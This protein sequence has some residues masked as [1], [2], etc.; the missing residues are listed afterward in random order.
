[1]ADHW[2]AGDRVSL[3]PNGNES[4]RVSGTI[5]AIEELAGMGSV[6]VEFDQAVRGCGWCSASPNELTKLEA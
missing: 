6:R 2:G 1:M 5:V 4:D 3:C